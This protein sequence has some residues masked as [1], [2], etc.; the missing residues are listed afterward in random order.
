M[1]I[2]EHKRRAKA[3]W[4]ALERLPHEDFMCHALDA[5]DIEAAPEHGGG[6]AAGELT[7]H[8][9]HLD[10]FT[11]MAPCPYLETIDSLILRGD[12]LTLAAEYHEACVAA[13]RTL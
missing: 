5:V 12:I 8:L 6:W 13:G 7:E 9:G 3:Y 4:A 1:K 11:S 2:K 10:T